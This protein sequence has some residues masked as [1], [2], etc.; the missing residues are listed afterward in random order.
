[1]SS[2]I[3]RSVVFNSQQLQKPL[4]AHNLSIFCGWNIASMYICHTSS[5][6]I[7]AVHRA[8]LHSSAQR[9]KR[10]VKLCLCPAKLKSIKERNTEI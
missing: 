7:I 9:R 1:M 10:Q 4:Q 2:A 8:D 3:Q 6:M 5:H